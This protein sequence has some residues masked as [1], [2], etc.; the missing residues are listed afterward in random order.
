[1]LSPDSAA[2][3][4]DD[5]LQFSHGRHERSARNL[6]RRELSP[7]RSEESESLKTT[8]GPEQRDAFLRR[9]ADLNSGET[10]VSLE[11]MN[12]DPFQPQEDF[13]DILDGR[14][15]RRLIPEI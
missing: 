4:N 9:H 11:P 2:P 3:P 15:G 8:T 6:E 13:Y 14:T 12:R 7:P 1:M 10:T 5:L